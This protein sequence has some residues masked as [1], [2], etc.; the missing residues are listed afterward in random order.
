MYS[1]SCC[2]G[3]LCWVGK[4]CLS[5]IKH[6]LSGRKIQTWTIPNISPTQIVF[7]FLFQ[8]LAWFSKLMWWYKLPA[9]PAAL[10]TWSLL[11]TFS[12]TWGSRTEF[13]GNMM[14]M[15]RRWWW[16]HTSQE[17]RRAEGK[18]FLSSCI[19][20]KLQLNHALLNNRAT[21]WDSKFGWGAY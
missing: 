4:Q 13:Q 17:S 5:P 15:Q 16:I 6:P 11:G 2:H 9:S 1:C 21:S 12:Q 10:G 19:V 8:F 14:A 18:V 20:E 7:F 3:L